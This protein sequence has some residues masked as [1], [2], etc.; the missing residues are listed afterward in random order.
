M[1]FCMD[2]ATAAMKPFMDTVAQLYLSYSILCPDHPVMVPPAPLQ[3]ISIAVITTHFYL[4]G[5]Y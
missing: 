3:V 5:T 4:L 1:E 2:V